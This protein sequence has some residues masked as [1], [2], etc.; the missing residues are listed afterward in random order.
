MYDLVAIGDIVTDFFIKLKDASVHCDVNKEH[1]TISMSFGDKIPYESVHTVRA[2]GNSPNAAVAASR[3]GLKTALVTNMGEDLNGKECLESLTKDG[4]A[5]EFVSVHKDKKTNC[6]YILWYEDDRTI[7]IKH[8]GY[9]RKLPDLNK[10]KWI[11][12]SSLGEDS[13]DYQE[14]I[15]TYLKNNPETLLA[16]QPGTFQIKLGAEKLKDIYERTEIL[17]CNV[18]E[19][20]KILDMNTLG[21]SELLKRLQALGPKKVVVT[22]GPKGAYAYDGENMWFQAPYPDP[23]PPLERTGAGDAFSSTIVSSLALGNDLPTSLSWGAVNSMS[24]VQ[25]VGAQKGLLN[26]TE[27]EEFLKKAGPDFKARK[28]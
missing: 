9:D 14:S 1:C 15:I 26:R 13:F 27:L 12:L 21:T 18:E 2:V 17:F 11:Y 8:E 10:P 28:M 5:T 19:A 16:F 24:V 4:V 23:K 20:E 22:D 3:L 25:E 7:L 6:H